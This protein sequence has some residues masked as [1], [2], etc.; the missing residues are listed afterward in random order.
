MPGC[1]DKFIPLW[2]EVSGGG[3]NSMLFVKA[4]FRFL[5][6]VC[7]IVAV[8]IG[9]TDS[10]RSVAT[11]KV[12]LLSSIDGLAYIWPQSV[13]FTQTLIEHYIH[14]EAWRSLLGFANDAPATAVLLSLA[15]IFWMIGYRKVRPRSQVFSVAM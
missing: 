15:M 10:V 13:T 5:S 6:F 14:P 4:F 8:L 12:D 7:L 1:G 3:S 2:V 9:V 11:N